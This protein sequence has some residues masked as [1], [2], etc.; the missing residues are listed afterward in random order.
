MPW[1]DD[2]LCRF[3]LARRQPQASRHRW[4]A[5]CPVHEADGEH[6]PSFSLWL[7]R[8]MD[9]LLVGCWGGCDKTQ[10]VKAVG[11]EMKDLFEPTQRDSRQT[12]RVAPRVVATYDY[13]DE[14]GALLY[15]A[16]RLEPKSFRQ[17]HMDGA[18]Y[19]RWGRGDARLVP[20]RLPFILARPNQPVCVCE[21]EK[22]ADNL[23]ALGVETTTGVG[24]CGE[25][26]HDEYSRL[27][28]VGG[29]RFAVIPHQDAPGRAHMERVC[30]SL[31]RHGAGA[32][33]WVDLPHKDVSDALAAGVDVLS[34]IRGVGEYRR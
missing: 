22:D 11:L 21:G 20:Y 24:G 13:L 32:V 10:A 28:C 12:P 19:W 27:L 25:G 16:V 4:S 15:Q 26:W 17:R 6:W 5:Y 2:I 34:I 31:I 23:A 9:R 33:R 8:E 18:G 29:R 7:G 30:G 3:R 1:W 14:G